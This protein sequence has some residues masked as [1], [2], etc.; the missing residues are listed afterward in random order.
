MNKEVIK[1]QLKERTSPH[2]LDSIQHDIMF[3]KWRVYHAK[4]STKQTMHT[5][6]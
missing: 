1:E 5:G 3:N 2:L 6:F 4:R